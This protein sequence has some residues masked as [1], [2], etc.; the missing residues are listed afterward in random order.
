RRRRPGPVL[1]PRRVYKARPALL[2]G[3]GRQ[4]R[5]RLARGRAELRSV[6]LQAEVRAGVERPVQILRIVDHRDDLQPRTAIGM[7]GQSMNV[8]G[9]RRLL[10][11][12]H[13]ILA[14]VSLAE[15]R[16]H[17][18][19]IAAGV[20]L[21]LLAWWGTTAKALTAATGDAA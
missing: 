2:G 9:D 17:D 4:R 8:L 20:D 10:A 13:A 1:W 16:R 7:R 15:I 12:R 3:F 21:G 5:V 19:Q 11:V 14:Q 18:L 6:R